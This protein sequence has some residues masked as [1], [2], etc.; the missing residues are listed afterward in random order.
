[1]TSRRSYVIITGGSEPVRGPRG[2]HRLGAPGTAPRYPAGPPPRQPGSRPPGGR[3]PHRARHRRTP[4]PA[5]FAIRSASL[6]VLLGMVAVSGW[7]AAAGATAFAQM[8]QP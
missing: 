1:M 5:V 4:R 2:R 7:F 8:I 3:R 6:V